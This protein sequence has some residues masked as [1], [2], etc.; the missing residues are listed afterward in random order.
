MMKKILYTTITAILFLGTVSTTKVQAQVVEEG[1]MIFDVYYGFPNLYTSI[2]KAEYV[3]DNPG[4]EY[5]N[6]KVGGI[7]PMGLRFEYLITEKIGLGVDM[8]YTN[9]TV[10]W[11]ET[12]DGNTYDYNVKVPRI[13]VMGKFNFHFAKSDKFDAYTAF[14]AGYGSFK[15]VTETN[16]P[17]YIF[18]NLENPIPVS[19]RFALGARYFFN[20]NLGI[21]LEFGL[22]GGA[23]INAGL[24]FKI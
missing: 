12:I 15:L 4:E 9:T 3:N 7:G 13:R 5:Q 8:N 22:L 23:L 20:D 2:L 10:D 18:T 14:G 24:S 1:T 11:N 6:V 17:N 21:N 16:D 19:I